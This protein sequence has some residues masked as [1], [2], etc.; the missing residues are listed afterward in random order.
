MTILKSIGAVLGGF[1]VVAGLSTLTDTFL[2]YIGVFPAATLTTGL[3]VLAL[4]YR[5][6]YTLL[7]GYITALLA[8]KN[9]ITHVWVLAGIG[10]LGGIVGVIVGWNLSDHWYPIMIAV[11]AIPSVILGGWLYLKNSK[12]SNK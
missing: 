11:T 5:I 4:V 12:A 6:I 10:Q 8:P 3:L 7:G 1:L 9:K 2:E